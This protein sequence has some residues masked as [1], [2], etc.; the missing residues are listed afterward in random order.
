VVPLGKPPLSASPPRGRIRRGVWRL[1]CFRLAD[2]VRDISAS[3]TAADINPALRG[4]YM[5]FGV[6]SATLY[7]AGLAFGAESLSRT[8]VFAVHARGG[9]L[10]PAGRGNMSDVILR[11]SPQTARCSS[12]LPAAEAMLGTPVR[13][14]CSDTACS[15]ASMSPIARPISPRFPTPR[16]GGE[17]GSVEFRV[18]R[19][20]VVRRGT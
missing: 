17:S 14:D 19:E 20:V 11:Q 3:L 4:M 5:A 13:G 7:A 2:R 8:S 12:F 1:S 16:R 9:S 10:S 18:R 6:V 15:I